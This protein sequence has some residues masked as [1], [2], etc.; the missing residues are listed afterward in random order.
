M[1]RNKKT[2]NNTLDF[3]EEYLTNN[4][5]ECYP[6][7]NI[8]YYTNNNMEILNNKYFCELLRMCNNK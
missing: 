2:H 7:N 3:K 1:G 6:Y 8:D 5:K 4:N